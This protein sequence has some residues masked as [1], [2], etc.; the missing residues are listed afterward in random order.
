MAGGQHHMAM[1]MTQQGMVPAGG[2]YGMQ[3]GMYAAMQPQPQPQAQ[4]QVAVG[5]ASAGQPQQQLSQQPDG[6]A[7]D[8][9]Y[10][11]ETQ[12]HPQLAPAQDNPDEMYMDPMAMV[13]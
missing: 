3:A 5:V 7:S 9:L 11:Q 8:P 2:A 13:R 6:A 4:P 12:T 10:A 1:V